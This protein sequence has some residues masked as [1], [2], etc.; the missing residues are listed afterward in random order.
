MLYDNFTCTSMFKIQITQPLSQ[1]APFGFSDYCHT[2]SLCFHLCID[3]GEQR[4]AS[5]K[6][7]IKS[8]NHMRATED[9]YSEVFKKKIFHAFLWA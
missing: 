5:Q 9:K 4:Y 2:C 8:H 1:R 6:S 3:G 7:N